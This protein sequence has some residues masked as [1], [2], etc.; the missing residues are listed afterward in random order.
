MP[1]TDSHRALRRAGIVIAVI[2][3]VIVVSGIGMRVSD[4]RE[5][6]E[7]TE[8]QAIPTVAVV[9]PTNGDAAARIEL[10]G[11]LEALSRAPLHARVSGYLKTWKVDI[12]AP[13]KAG[14]LLAEIEA[15]DIEQQLLQAEADL[16]SAEA[17]AALAASTAKRWQSM[18]GRD[19]VS[20]QE[21][22][23]KV[24]DLAAKQA[25]VKA[26]RANV[27]RL[28]TMKGFTRIVAPFDGVVTARNTD[29]G[30]L[31][32]A[33]GGAGRELFVVSNT[34][35]LRVYV[36][37]P[38]VYASQLNTD[39]KATI[40]VPDQPG[41]KYSAAVEA[42]A[43][44]VNVATGTTLMQLIVDN[45][46]GEL[47]PGGYASVSFELE[48]EAHALRVPA[49]ALIFDQS[50]LRVATVGSDNRVIMKPVTI[51]RDH[52][53]FIEVATGLDA[54]DRVIATPPDGLIAGSA[55]R[56]L[57]PTVQ[58]AGNAAG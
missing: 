2:A 24:G 41:K 19:S 34:G 27:E 58:E 25:L 44:A 51:A 54:S 39:A 17:N 33:G 43:R 32:T 40:T 52:G 7:W 14:Q 30:E 16:A 36:N 13:V 38:Q 29:I 50:G 35:R 31:I 22:E 37:V 28:R 6:S 15:P 45:K 57:E 4:H 46:S 20:R 8:E 21:V 23:E 26:E 5:L 55:V 49:S 42:S 9:T 12:G 3:I 18:L 56:V 10:P 1:P 11:R 53:A 48:G 47:L